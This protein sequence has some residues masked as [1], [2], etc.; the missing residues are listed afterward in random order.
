MQGASYRHPFI[1]DA[2]L[3]IAYNALYKRRDY[4]RSACATREI[5]R[6]SWVEKRSGQCTVGLPDMIRG[7]VGLCFGTIFVEPYSRKLGEGWPSYRD[8]REAHALGMAQLDFY[9]RWAEES[10]HVMLVTTKG[11]LESLCQRWGVGTG[12][13]P[14]ADSRLLTPHR[15]GI[16]LLMEGG[17]PILEPKELERWYERGLRIVGPAWDTTRYAGGTWS[18]GRLTKLGR[19]LLNVMAEFGV[20]LDVSHLSHEALYE[21]LDAFEGRHVIASHSNPYRYAPTPR[22]LPDKAIERIAERG[23]VIGVVLYNRFLKKEWSGKKHDVTLDDVVRMIDHI[24]QVT[25]SANHVGIGSDYDGG[26]GYNDIPRELNTIRDHYK[27]GD[28]LLER[29]FEMRHVAQI[30]RDNWLRILREALPT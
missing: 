13:A 15:V 20:I 23:G 5:E 11:E 17:D 10:P 8:A 9:R 7:R 26:I 1:V 14:T 21:A 3:D 24:C 30:M 12:A 2:H 4:R 18:G 27:I 28:A 6:G 22:H 19:E 25:G 29:G 16:V